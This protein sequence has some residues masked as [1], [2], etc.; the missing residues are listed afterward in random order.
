[1]ERSAA[2]EKVFNDYV[3]H[4]R[5]LT[6]ELVAYQEKPSDVAGLV[7]GY[8]EVSDQLFRVILGREENPVDEEAAGAITAMIGIDLLVGTQA[9]A[10]AIWSLKSGV[11]WT[12]AVMTSR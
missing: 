7:G 11:D 5:R 3:D 2:F 8:T 4:A 10:L 1:M 12:S 9:A 6:E